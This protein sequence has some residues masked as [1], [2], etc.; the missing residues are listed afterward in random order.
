MNNV[1]LVSIIIPFYNTSKKF[2]QEAIESVFAQT[3]GH[4]ELFLVDDGSTGDCTEIAK[5]YADDYPERVTYLKHPGHQNRGVSATRNLGIEHAK[6]EY[7]AFLDSDDIWL[8]KKL[9]QQLAIMIPRTEVGMIYGRSQYWWSWS[10]NPK[11]QVPDR[12]QEHGISSNVIIDPPALLQFFIKGKTAIPVISSVMVRHEVAEHIGGFEEVF[13][14]DSNNQYH[15]QT[16]YAK[17]CLEFPVFVSNKCWD[18]YR[19]LP[20][21]MCAV[22]KEKGPF[23]VEHMNY[24]DWLAN[25]LSRR[26]FRATEIWKALKMEQT[27]RHHWKI[28]RPIKRAQR[29]IWRRQGPYPLCIKK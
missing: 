1:P 28:G 17:V 14:G 20:D 25:Y 23:E 8:P 19:Q 2:I 24:L 21:S 11:E 3:F 10:N 22:S 26:G 13:G 15:D 29:F 16:F 5:Y 18:R 27:L 9:E 4:W 6:G 7:L 12:V